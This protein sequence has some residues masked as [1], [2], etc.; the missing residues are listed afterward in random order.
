MGSGK[1]SVLQ[2]SCSEQFRT[3]Y[4]LHFPFNTF[5]TSKP[6]P[7]DPRTHKVLSRSPSENVLVRRVAMS[8]LFKVTFIV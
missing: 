6:W 1:I 4:N 3:P 2:V 7:Y 8:Q 5:W